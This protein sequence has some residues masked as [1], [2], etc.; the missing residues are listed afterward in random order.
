MLGCTHYPLLKPLVQE[1]IGQRVKLID[2]AGE[3]AAAL[4]GLLEREGLLASADSESEPTHRFAV[5]DDPERFR[6]VGAGFLGQGLAAVEVV[7]PGTG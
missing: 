1:V 3:T 7:T 6:R 5:S 4:A 2:S